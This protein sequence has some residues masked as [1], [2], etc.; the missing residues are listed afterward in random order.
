MDFCRQ[1]FKTVIVPGQIAP[2]GSFPEELRRT[3]PYGYSLFNLDAM[4][5]VCQS[6]D[7]V[8]T[9]SG[10]SSGAQN[11]RTDTLWTFET[12]DGRGVRKAL[13]YMVPFIADKRTWSRPPD[14]MYY[15][16]WPVRHPALYFGGIAYNRSDYIELWKKLDPDPTVDEV[17]RNY[18]VRQPVLWVR[19]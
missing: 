13:A 7:P 12:D 11:D 6:L 16:N 1:R 5:M 10:E 19:F 4:V 17:I 9:L 8:G 15:D 2:D 14:V 3:K 18:I